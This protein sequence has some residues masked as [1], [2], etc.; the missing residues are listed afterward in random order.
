[1]FKDLEV[2]R[3]AHAMAS[4]AGT[5]QSLVAQ[6]MA[7]ADTP[8]YA[9]RDLQPFRDLYESRGATFTPA[10]TR[11]G[12]LITARPGPE[13]RAGPRE[14]AV[15]DPNGNSVSLEIE[16]L[17]A[18]D[19]KRQHDRAISIYRSSLSVLRSAIGRQ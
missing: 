9:A 12:H 1:M 13:L 16:M 10:A 6:N 8:G 15:A 19:V 5:R 4:H 18:V 17:N 14:D 7:N 2:F 11:A 3:L